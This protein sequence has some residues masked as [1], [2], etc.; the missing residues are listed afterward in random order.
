MEIKITKNNNSFK[1]KYPK[2]EFILDSR[3]ME[4]FLN[5][6]INVKTKK[7]NTLGHNL[8]VEYNKGTII[9]EDYDY[10]YKVHPFMRKYINEVSKHNT[11]LRNILI[12]A[13]LAGIIG[14][15]TMG[16]VNNQQVPVENPSISIADDIS[17]DYTSNMEIPLETGNFIPSTMSSTATTNSSSELS[18]TIPPK[19]QQ[20]ENKEGYVSIPSSEIDLYSVSKEDIVDDNIFLGLDIESQAFTDRNIS[21]REYL[22]IIEKIANKYFLDPNLVLAVATQEKGKHSPYVDNGGGLGIMQIQVSQHPDGSG[23]YT[24]H[25]ENNQPVN[26]YF[27]YYL[28]NYQTVEGNIEAGCA[29]LRYY[30]DYYSGNI[31]MALLAYNGGQGN[32]NKA[33]FN[34]SQSTGLTKEEII[35][36]KEDLGWKERLINKNYLN[37]VLRWL[38]SP[39]IQVSYIDEEGIKSYS[40]NIGQKDLLR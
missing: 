18:S 31:A 3:K 24:Y 29:L 7:V 8:V 2:E 10:L 33:I 34:Y 12:S 32:V 28:S 9:I 35:N 4:Y 21:A 37:D 39:N 22:P 30:I 1:V 11:N 6:L 26:Q 17:D 23:F 16:F 20:L 38:E 36:N 27:A 25:N 19:I 13:G 40:C 14:M 15:N 5:K